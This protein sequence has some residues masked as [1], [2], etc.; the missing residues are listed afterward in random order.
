MWRG[1]GTGVQY[2]T[3]L[4]EHTFV[5][6]RT[7][8]G[9]GQKQLHPWGWEEG[10]GSGDNTNGGNAVAKNN[11]RPP[12]PMAA[13]KERETTVHCHP[14]LSVSPEQLHRGHILNVPLKT[15]QSEGLPG[16]LL[17]P[18]QHISSFSAPLNILQLEGPHRRSATDRATV[19]TGALL[20]TR[21]QGVRLQSHLLFSTS[22]Y[23]LKNW[24][25]D[26]S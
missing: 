8:L 7:D 25:Y 14:P 26:G 6:N 16:D 21:D 13:L 12:C 18:G 22:W 1:C 10:R 4:E 19:Q 15:P 20:E 9:Y 2:L 5:R 24:P 23:L 3:W 11:K 17:Q